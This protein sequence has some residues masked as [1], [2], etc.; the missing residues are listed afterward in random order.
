MNKKELRELEKEY[1]ISLKSFLIVFC[2]ICNDTL[3]REKVSHDDIKH[4]F[5]E[6]TKVG[7]DYLSKNINEIYTGNVI[8]VKDSF[9]FIAPYKKPLIQEYLEI[10]D[11]EFIEDKKERVVEE[12]V[13][14]ENLSLY[15][16]SELGKKYKEERRLTEYRKV[17]R[18]IKK[19][20]NE[21]GIKEF[22]K[23]KEKIKEMNYN[24]KY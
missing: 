3:L 20:N 15:E 14:L 4:I 17:C 7:F 12:I 22:H 8:L 9:G 23:K 1:S 13:N 10:P 2:G 18:L 6:L 5:P 16:L 21:S 19:I 24:D 11:I